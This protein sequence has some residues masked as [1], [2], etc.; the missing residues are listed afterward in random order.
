MRVGLLSK[1]YDSENLVT[2]DRARPL[3]ISVPL[4]TSSEHALLLGKL[5]Y[6][7]APPKIT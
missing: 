6:K 1:K 3:T 4:F 5:L 7:I 2:V